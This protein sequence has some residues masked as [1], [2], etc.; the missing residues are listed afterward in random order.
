MKQLIMVGLAIASIVAA[1]CGR[2]AEKAPASEGGAATAPVPASGSR[3]QELA[4]T[5]KTEPEPPKMGDNTFDVHVMGGNDQPVTDAEV[6][7]QLYM[8][9]M[10]EMKMPEMRTTVPLKHEGSGR[11]RGKGNVA[12]AGAW[13]ATVKVMRSGQDIGSRTFNVTAQ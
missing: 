12:M 1:A 6:S 7:I 10:P 11:Y 9:A 13:D 4:I 2:P 5:F 8:P 3:A